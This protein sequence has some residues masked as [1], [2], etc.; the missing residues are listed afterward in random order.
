MRRDQLIGKIKFLN[1]DRRDRSVRSKH[2]VKLY[3]YQFD[4]SDMFEK[5]KQIMRD[6]FHQI[7]SRPRHRSPQVRQSPQVRRSSLT[8]RSTRRTH[9][10]KSRST[11]KYKKPVRK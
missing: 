5:T 9:H 8:L 3:L 11:R 6:F 2:Y 4:D 7:G 1:F 10:K